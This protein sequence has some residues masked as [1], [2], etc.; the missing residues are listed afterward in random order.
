[1]SSVDYL[2]GTG[3]ASISWNRSSGA[4]EKLPEKTINPL[5]R[6]QPSYIARIFR[7]RR[8]DTRI[9]DSLAFKVGD[10][11]V[12]TP[13][14]YQNILEQLRD[15]AAGAEADGRQ[16]E[17]I[18]RAALLLDELADNVTL[19]NLNRQVETSS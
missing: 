16:A 2:A 7:T 4:E 6:A 11:R 17:V 5:G 13:G 8:S 19:L 3:I 9:L 14:N 10:E 15:V 18:A 1:M 12:L